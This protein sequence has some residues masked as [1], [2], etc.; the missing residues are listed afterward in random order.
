MV[1]SAIKLVRYSGIRT[2]DACALDSARIICGTNLT[3]H[4]AHA[5]T[6]GQQ[7]NADTAGAVI[8]DAGRVAINIGLSRQF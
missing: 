1:Q 5:F 4:K 2:A 6:V 7:T 8:P 3:T